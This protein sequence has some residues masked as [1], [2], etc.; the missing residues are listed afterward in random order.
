V[1]SSG[2]DPRFFAQIDS[3]Q[4]NRRV[5]KC[6]MSAGDNSVVSNSSGSSATGN[7]PMLPWNDV[8]MLP[9]KLAGNLLRRIPRKFVR[10][11]SNFLLRGRPTYFQHQEYSKLGKASSNQKRSGCFHLLLPLSTRIQPSSALHVHKIHQE[12]LTVV[13][14]FTLLSAIYFATGL[15][16]LSSDGA[17]TS[18][19][20]VS[21][22]STGEKAV[23]HRRGVVKAQ[24]TTPRHQRHLAS[25]GGF[26]QHTI[27]PGDY[28]V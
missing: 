6:K 12:L 21:Y 1:S 5:E 26:S 14:F 11:R 4:L 10:W 27:L 15:L 28:I 19:F 22:S 9:A 8:I 7:D 25:A 13:V 16:S 18:Y 20:G 3:S 17:R 24:P 2:N 23:H